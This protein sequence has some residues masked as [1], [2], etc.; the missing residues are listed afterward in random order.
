VIVAGCAIG[1]ARRLSLFAAA[2]IRS[3]SSV[4]ERV[5]K[6]EQQQPFAAEAVSPPARA[7]LWS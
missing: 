7:S 4:K 1:H 6:P 3:T 2:L 5:D